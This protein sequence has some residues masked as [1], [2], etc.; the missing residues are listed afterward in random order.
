MTLTFII[1]LAFVL[2][3][4]YL[5]TLLALFPKR[6]KELPPFIT[7]LNLLYRI[8]LLLIILG[9][10]IPCIILLWAIVPFEYLTKYLFNSTKYLF[11]STKYLFKRGKL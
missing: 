11:N 5:I 2:S 6:P 1:I 10:T 7:H 4:I 3:T 9:P 8:P